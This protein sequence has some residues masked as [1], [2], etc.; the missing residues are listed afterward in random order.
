MKTAFSCLAVASLLTGCTSLM[1]PVLSPEALA[2]KTDD[3]VIFRFATPAEAA[4]L[5]TRDDLYTAQVQAREAGIRA[6]DASATGF[7]DYADDYRADV[8]EWTE[9]ERIALTVAI[10][11]TLSK[12]NGIDSLLPDEVYLVKAGSVVEG[13]LPHTRGDAII[14]AGGGIPS[15]NNLT[16]LFLH[17]LHHVLSRANEDLHDDYFA[18]IGFEPCAFEE[19]TNLRL[20]RLSNPDAP[21][22]GHFVPTELPGANGVI[23][24]LH[25]SRNYDGSGALPDYFGFGLLPVSVEGGVCT[26]T[27]PSPTGLLAPNQ[28]PGFLEALGGNTGYIIHPE[29]TLADNFVFWAMDREGL[30]T[31]ELPEKVGEF[32]L[33]AA[34]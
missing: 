23:P 3:G 32:W 21:V 31:P 34:K 24:F 15:G 5:L 19:P 26:A 30:P 25:A 8:L 29:E 33:N 1:Q 10:N 20:A 9:E 6:R 12:V 7:D 13:G 4:D 27:I 28:A 22:Y 14:F 11:S 17:E 18:L 16:A 2:T